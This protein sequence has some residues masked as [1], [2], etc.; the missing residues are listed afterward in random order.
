MLGV[1]HHRH[2]GH[3]HQHLRHQPPG[4]DGEVPQ[5]QGPQHAEGVAEGVGGVEGGQFQNVHNEFH[6]QQLQD[7]GDVVFLLH[8]QEIQ[9]GREG[10]GIF[11][12]QIP[13]GRDEQVEKQ[14]RQADDFQIG[15]DEGREIVVVDLLGK[16]ENGGG[17]NHD[18]GGVVHHQQ[19]AAL[20][21]AGH[22]HV[23]PLGVA[24]LGEGIPPLPGG[25]GLR[26]RLLGQREGADGDGL[27]LLPKLRKHGLLRLPRHVNHGHVLA[28]ASP[29]GG[30]F[31]RE[32]GVPHPAAEEGGVFHDVLGKAVV[33]APED[34][35]GVRLLD[36]AGGV[37]LGLQ[38]DIGLVPLHQQ[39]RL[40]GEHRHGGLLGVRLRLGVRRRHAGGH[41]V[42][43]R[44]GEAGQR[45]PGGDDALQNVLLGV[46]VDHVEPGPAAG[47][48]E[49]TAH[50]IEIA[51]CAQD[52][53]HL[54]KFGGKAFHKAAPSYNK[55][56][57]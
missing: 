5:Y 34:A 27:Q 10:G 38:E 32:V 14:H 24:H 50:H 19:N 40:A 56:Q 46:A 26:Q 47:D 21:D 51:A 23:G 52:V 1:V 42:L 35:A 13:Q 36:G 48:G 53:V 43:R 39:Q 12:Q 17:E 57:R 29:D 4:L 55:S 28:G 49:I 3:I 7:E 16:A 30:D 33:A 45:L 25:D 41:E 8:Q 54:G 6:Q 22:R 15:A 11:H 44:G 20:H 37:G 31:Q 2:E 9:A 18:A